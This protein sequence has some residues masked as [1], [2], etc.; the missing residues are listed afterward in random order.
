MLLFRTCYQK[1]DPR[2][3]SETHPTALPQ[4]GDEVAYKTWATAI[5]GGWVHL[6][7]E[8][9]QDTHSRPQSP[10]KDTH[11][12]DAGVRPVSRVYRKCLRDHGISGNVNMKGAQSSHTVPPMSSHEVFKLSK[13]L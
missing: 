11:K 12:N 5:A 4:V 10:D 9:N 3:P 1:R 6:H 2:S 7:S 13:M 8:E